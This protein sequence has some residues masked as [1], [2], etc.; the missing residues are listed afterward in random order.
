MLDESKNL[1]LGV[2]E[3]GRHSVIYTVKAYGISLVTDLQGFDGGFLRAS[4]HH[5]ICPGNCIRKLCLG[6]CVF[7]LAP[8]VSGVAALE[9]GTEGGDPALA[10]GVDWSVVVEARVGEEEVVHGNDE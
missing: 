10:L 7:Q 9:F 4:R 5:L 3:C 6:N 8:R 1:G 2:G